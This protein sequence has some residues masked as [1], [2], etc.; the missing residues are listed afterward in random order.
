[1]LLQFGQEVEGIA[2]AV[3]GL[4]EQ[5]SFAMENGLL[6]GPLADIMPTAGLCRVGRFFDLPAILLVLAGAA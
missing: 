4:V 1:M 2:G 3:L 5:R 6:E